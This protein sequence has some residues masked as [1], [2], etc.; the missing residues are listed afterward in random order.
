MGARAID[1]L[2]TL[3]ICGRTAVRCLGTQSRHGRE[4]ASALSDVRRQVAP[5]VLADYAVQ[6]TDAKRQFMAVLAAA[7][8]AGLSW[9]DMVDALN[10]FHERDM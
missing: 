9:P 3:D 4:L 6:P 8:A 1:A 7:A 10:H 5:L 2:L